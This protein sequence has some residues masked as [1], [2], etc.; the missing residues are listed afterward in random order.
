MVTLNMSCGKQL[1]G[2][3]SYQVWADLIELLIKY[4]F[5]SKLPKSYHELTVMQMLPFDI[6]EEFFRMRMTEIIRWLSCGIVAP[7]T[8]AH[9]FLVIITQFP[10]QQKEDGVFFESIL[11]QCNYSSSLT[12]VK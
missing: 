5:L 10:I 8:L 4:D 2:C 1:P 12:Y 6:Q 9:P 11:R 3:T 7:P